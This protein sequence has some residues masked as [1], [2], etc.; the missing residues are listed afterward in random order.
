MLNCMSRVS[1]QCLCSHL[2]WIWFSVWFRKWR[3]PFDIPISL[4]DIPVN[5]VLIFKT[6]A[7]SF[8]AAANSS[9]ILPSQ[10]PV[11]RKTLSEQDIT[12]VHF[13][14]VKEKRNFLICLRSSDWSESTEGRC[15]S[16]GSG[17]AAAEYRELPESRGLSLGSQSL[18]LLW[19][20]RSQ[21]SFLF[22]SYKIVMI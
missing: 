13:M 4:L 22:L 3:C 20:V 11:V 1:R 5:V 16:G 9:K 18:L 17:F 14:K 2:E 10:I 21:F 19:W 6:K 12:N 7:N 15:T 8:I